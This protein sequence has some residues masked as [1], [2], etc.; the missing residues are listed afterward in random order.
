[1]TDYF[2]QFVDYYNEIKQKNP[3]DYPT[4]V[5]NIYSPENDC[6]IK[7]YAGIETYNVSA[8]D[9]IEFFI[10]LCNSDKFNTKDDIMKFFKFITKDY[11]NT[12]N[13]YLK[14]YLLDDILYQKIV[15]IRIYELCKLSVLFMYAFIEKI[16]LDILSN[17]ML[18]TIIKLLDKNKNEDLY[19]FIIFA[20]IRGLEFDVKTM[21]S[22]KDIGFDVSQIKSK[23]ITINIRK[24]NNLNYIEKIFS[25]DFESCKI[26][27]YNSLKEN[28]MDCTK[29]SLVFDEINFQIQELFQC[30]F[31]E[32][33]IK[34]KLYYEIKINE[35]DIFLLSNYYLIEKT[36]DKLINDILTEF[37]IKNII[38]DFDKLI[39]INYLKNPSTIKSPEEK[40]EWIKDCRYNYREILEN[41][42]AMKFK[43]KQYNI[44]DIKIPLQIFKKYI[45]N[46]VDNIDKELEKKRIYI[47]QDSEDKLKKREEKIKKLKQDRIKIFESVKSYDIIKNLYC[48]EY[49]KDYIKLILFEYPYVCP[50]MISQLNLLNLID[51]DIISIIFALNLSDCLQYIFNN[52]IRL[53]HKYTE[54][55]LYTDNI[56]EFLE[57][58]YEC[59]IRLTN[60]AYQQL[61]SLISKTILKTIDLKKYLL[62]QDNKLVESLSE[63]LN[64][65]KLY[66]QIEYIQKNYSTININDLIN[67]KDNNAKIYMI[68]YINSK[69]NNSKSNNILQENNNVESPKKKIILKKVVKKVV[70]NIDS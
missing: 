39:V 46:Y 45:D 24:Y 9:V 57:K 28:N 35:Q 34:L 36:D 4:N 18:R 2:I 16:P 52:K 42:I 51:D 17:D 31:I 33:I 63:K 21:K 19:K 61:S 29:I 14:R 20:N 3:H 12:N 38:L 10:H 15:H 55:I 8:F 59:N 11:K 65:L 25:K 53:E 56:L 66:E 67:I 7:G 23:D 27:F 58:M 40:Y 22:L 43:I 48:G 44:N 37:Q 6:F 68:N 1:M 47:G 62:D 70:K 69:L 5:K 13:K 60:N 41:I 64:K 49:N 26:Q 30:Y 54:Y 50:D 32:N